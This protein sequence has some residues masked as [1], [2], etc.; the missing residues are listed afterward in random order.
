MKMRS[1]RPVEGRV[2][3]YVY[4]GSLSA[5]RLGPQM[6]GFKHQ[7]SV[8]VKCI[9]RSVC[10]PS[11]VYSS[12][13]SIYVLFSRS[14]PWM[15]PPAAASGKVSAIGTSE[16]TAEPLVLPSFFSWMLFSPF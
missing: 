12:P 6:G 2:G 4:Q 5:G 1:P 16:V 8:K 3:N 15:T 9:G 14:R 10:T 7:N 11:Y 13:P